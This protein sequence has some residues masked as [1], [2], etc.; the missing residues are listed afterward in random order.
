MTVCKRCVMDDSIPSVKFNSDGVCCYCELHDQMVK[1]Y[2]TGEEGQLKIDEI[3]KE[4]KEL[5]R[6]K[7]Y[8][9][10]I[11]ISGGCDSSF[12]L[13][14]AKTLGLRV[15]AVTLDNTWS[16]EIAKENVKNM[17]DKLDVDLYTY[18]IDAQEFDDISRSFLYASV[19]DADIPSDIAI[20]SLYYKVMEEHDIPCS[21]CGHS[22][23]TE[24]TVPL[25]WTYMDSKY[26]E[27]VQKQF[28]TMPI[29]TLLTLDMDYWLK[30]INKKRVRLLYYL[31]YQK[32][33]VKDFLNKNFGWQW[34][35]GHHHENEYTKFVKT[36]LLP[37]KFN[38]DKRYVEFSALV[39]SGNMSRDQALEEL[40]TPV[41]V[42]PLFLDSVLKRLK[43]SE[44][45]LEDIMDLPIK[46]YRD[47]E[48]YRD[49][50]IENREMFHDMVEK[51][52]IS[53]TFYEKYTK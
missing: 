37:K 43:L 51:G 30:N 39:R 35:G 4:I 52:L 6:G 12:L 31:E 19:P 33:E 14:K 21:L 45:Q 3:V 42:D 15:L 18:F 8:D 27:S 11:G 10:I 29:D 28:G 48:T 26:I 50:F 17:C 47:Y 22:F 44:E 2:P 41:E 9:C 13:Y 36:Y 1:E 25:G 34:Y 49:Y 20:A 46:S 32:E 53:R 38:I 40:K 5:G 23:R 16:T 7:K 24:G